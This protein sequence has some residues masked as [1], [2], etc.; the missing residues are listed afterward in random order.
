MG[1]CV[2]VQPLSLLLGQSPGQLR[3]GLEL[4]GGQEGPTVPQLLFF[5]VALKPRRPSVKMA[6]PL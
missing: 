3:A 4:L 6:L 2:Y 1:M 5:F